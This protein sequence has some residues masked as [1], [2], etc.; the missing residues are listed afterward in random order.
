MENATMNKEPVTGDMLI[1]NIIKKY[2][3][4]TF[5]QLTQPMPQFIRRKV[6]SGY[7]LMMLAIS[8]SPVTGSLFSVAFSIINLLRKCTLQ[9]NKLFL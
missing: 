5:L 1:A 8:I 7:F 6:A 4:A 2:P 3:D 9:V